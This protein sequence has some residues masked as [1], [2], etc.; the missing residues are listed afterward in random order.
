MPESSETNDLIVNDGT[1][2][3]NEDVHIFGKL[4]VNGIESLDDETTYGISGG[5][6]STHDHATEHLNLG[7]LTVTGL[8][9]NGN[10]S[11]TG[12]TT[13][14]DMIVND[15]LTVL[16]DASIT[17]DL[18]AAKVSV[19]GGTSS[20]FLKADGTV[21]TNTYLTSSAAFSGFPQGTRMIFQQSTAPTGWTKDTTDTNQHALRVVSG[22]VSSGGSVDFT[23]A[24]SNRTI[25]ANI[26]GNSG[27][28]NV[29]GNTNNQNV[30][31]PTGLSNKT[32]G[33]ICNTERS[34][35]SANNTISMI[36]ISQTGNAVDYGDLTEARNN[37]R[38]ACAS[39]T[40]G[41]IFGGKNPSI[42]NTI[43]LITIASLGDAQKFGDLQNTARERGMGCSNAIRGLVAGGQNP[44][45]TSNIDTVMIASKGN[46]ITFGSLSASNVN[47]GT[48]AATNSPVRAVFS[49]GQAPS[50][51]NAMQ[52]I[53]IATGG[54]TSDF[55]DLVRAQ[56]GGA[57]VSNGH[58]GL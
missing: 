57:A 21:D 14:E 42:T 51:T 4:Y 12:T 52:Y 41:L 38:G 7:N 23:T 24:F 18:T 25:S 53:A 33:L 3:F 49:G 32:R 37:I 58:G 20:G 16:D 46:S 40:R 36:T 26:S 22:T 13:T 17:G 47:A 48:N 43:D 30:S 19:T 11:I 8:T 6:G 54:D 27:S 10:A 1:S 35:A 9:V 29:N 34:G 45:T 56:R 5:G 55:A 28:E 50:N 2:Y 15:D 31:G 44:S 39:P